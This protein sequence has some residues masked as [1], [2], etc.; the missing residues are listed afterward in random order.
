MTH[1]IMQIKEFDPTGQFVVTV[2][3]VELVEPAEGPPPA[4]YTPPAITDYHTDQEAVLPHTVFNFVFTRNVRLTHMAPFIDQERAWAQ[5]TFLPFL[6]RAGY[7]DVLVVAL[8][9]NIN[10]DIEWV[11]ARAAR[12]EEARAE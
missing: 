7:P 8:I 11:V 12:A 2:Y 5:N 3:E 10:S 4:A 1:P 6:R 9:N